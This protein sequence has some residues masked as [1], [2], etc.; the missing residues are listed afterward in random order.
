MRF[1]K[2]LPQRISCGTCIDQEK[3]PLHFPGNALS[4]GKLR[5]SAFPKDCK[6]KPPRLCC[7]FCENSPRLFCG[8]QDAANCR[9]K[10]NK[11]IDGTENTHAVRKR[12]I[13]I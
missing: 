10:T 11:S 1:L 8:A 13:F 3:H 9:K 12:D 6:E 2:G 5:F 7:V 4:S